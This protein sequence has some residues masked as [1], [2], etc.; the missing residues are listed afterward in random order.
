LPILQQKFQNSQTGIWAYLMV[1]S[2][3]RRVELRQVTS[4]IYES[5]DGS[6]TQL[7]DSVSAA[8][9]VKT[10]DGTQ[11]KFAA[12]AINNEFR[13]TE[14]KDRNGNYISATYNPTNGHL[15][16]ITDTLGRTV[17]FVYDAGDNLQAIRQTWAGVDHD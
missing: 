9:I 13:C 10:S 8:P 17:S 3:G 15:L 12:V 7:D 14:I 11:L 1:T 16:T 6:Y 2:S 4:N 5:M